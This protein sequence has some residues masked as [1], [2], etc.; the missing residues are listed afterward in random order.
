MYCQEKSELQILK[1]YL[2]TQIP[3]TPLPPNDI[4]LTPNSTAIKAAISGLDKELARL[5]REERLVAKFTSNNNNNNASTNGATGATDDANDAVDDME[6][7]KMTKEDAEGSSKDADG[8]VDDAAMAVDIN[9]DNEKDEEEWEEATPPPPSSPTTKKHARQEGG[10]GEE[11]SEDNN[12]NNNMR[13]LN[14]QRHRCRELASSAVTRIAGANVKVATPFGALGLALHAALVGLTTDNNANNDKDPMFRCTGVPDV[15]V[16]SQLLRQSNATKAGNGGGG[17]APPIREL[18]RGALVPPEWEENAAN[19]SSKAT[20]GDAVRGAI[21]FRYK[22]GKEAYSID[23]SGHTN[24]A[25]T[26]YLALQ[27][28]AVVGSNDGEGDVSVTFG[29]LPS[30]APKDNANALSKQLKFPLGK[31]VN[32]DGFTAAKT[33]NG[34]GGLVSPSLFYVSLSDLLMEFHSFFGMLLQPVTAM[35]PTREEECALDMD[36]Q[37][38]TKN[39]MGHTTTLT[40]MPGIAPPT[41]TARAAVDRPFDAN[42][43]SD[44]LRIMNSQ[45]QRGRRG[46]FDGDL[47]PGG[48]QPGGLLHDV[49]PGGGGSQ[50]GPNHPMFDRT[51]GEDDGYYPGYEDDFG[52]GFGNGGGSFGMPGVGGGMGMRPRF[53]PYGP[54]GG[55]TEPG[56]GGGQFFPGRGSILGREGRGGRGGGRGGGRDGRGGRGGRGR[57][58]MPPP[59]GFGN[60]NPDHM[61]PPGGGYFS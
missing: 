27:L 50:V 35:E 17:F 57:G 53:D 40:T 30:S 15:N 59:G 11:P 60:P 6:Y 1:T 33:K 3:N 28:L 9:D 43:N 54:P 14:A 47:L 7:V 4:L 23:S 56:R 37:M 58:R 39:V 29:T 16:T 36:M 52:G 26:V 18:P 41:A 38:P 10:K 13:N 19:T 55:P 24:D 48:P 34:G 46:D 5:E 42:N 22:C 49:P 61:T 51:F 20:N 44:P 21:C 45:Q 2:R 31:H 25:T 12:N 8:G 32:L